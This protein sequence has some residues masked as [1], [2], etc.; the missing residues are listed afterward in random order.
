MLVYQTTT[1]V[2]YINLAELIK[3]RLSRVGKVLA[4]LNG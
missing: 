2:E 4:F 3:C 1:D